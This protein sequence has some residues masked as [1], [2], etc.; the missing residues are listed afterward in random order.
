[1]LSLVSL[2]ALASPEI[3]LEAVVLVQQGPGTC[4]GA[5]VDDRGTVATAYHC[6][7]PGGRPRVTT[8]GGES[9]LGRV[10]RVDVAHDLALV[11]VPALAGGAW[12]PLR[13]GAPELGERVRTLG[14]PYGARLP[15][16][17]V[18]GTLRWSV[19]EGIVSAV[20][21]RSLQ[22]TA[23]IN[24]GNSG[25][26]VLDAEGRLVGVVSRRYGGQGIGFAGRADAV[27]GLLA[28][29]GRGFG[30][31]GGTLSLDVFTSVWEA[32]EGA[33][34]VG[35][36]VEVSFRDRVVLGAAGALPLDARWSVTRFGTAQHFTEGEL[37]L[38]LRQ[39]LLRGQWT[40]FVE[41]YGGG[42][43]VG[44]LRPHPEVDWTRESLPAPLI[45]AAV[46]IAGAAVDVGFVHVEGAW[47]VRTLVVLRWP[48][49]FWMF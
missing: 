28:G 16:G 11:A 30:P 35:A 41:L 3:P 45:G 21:P 25:G 17:F 33:V 26:P 8:H 9:A 40:S 1:M 29:E 10:T 13:E 32:A 4:A 48:G 7:A 15:A 2:L 18:E 20:G 14:H 12:I 47:A 27:A 23:P 19:S 5:F 22:F 31:L 38:G 42:A 43:S 24:P 34:S 36:R 49:V 37:R 6:V 44:V 46:S 39:R